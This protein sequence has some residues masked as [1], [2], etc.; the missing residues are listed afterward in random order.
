MPFVE[1][2]GE[3]KV[4]LEAFLAFSM[5]YSASDLFEIGMIAL[6]KGARRAALA[7][8]EMSDSLGETYL[9]LKRLIYDHIVVKDFITPKRREELHTQLE[10]T[11]YAKEQVLTLLAG[12]SIAAT[13]DM[14]SFMSRTFRGYNKI[15]EISVSDAEIARMNELDDKEKRELRVALLK[16]LE[17]VDP[18]DAE[19][20]STK[21]HGPW[22]Y[23]DMELRVRHGDELYLLCIPIK[24][25]REIDDVVPV[26]I[27]YQIARPFM[28]F[29]KAV[30]VFI[31]ARPC[32]QYLH[33]YVKAARETQGWAIG[34][35]EHIQLAKLLKANGLL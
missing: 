18:V 29:P 27:A 32:S 25:G 31:T 19:R 23:S 14:H 17:G 16:I 5:T 34:I 24:S 20:E 26:S 4:D 8:F 11:A 13:V 6:N 2:N 22:E 10:S 35:I 33:N 21:P 28:F 7:F 3:Y 30:V 1:M 15:P 12:P 9:R